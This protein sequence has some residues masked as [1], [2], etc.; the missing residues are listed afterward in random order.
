MREK[1]V[2]CL[3]L[4][5][6]NFNHSA[7]LESL[8]GVW[9]TRNPAALHMLEGQLWSS[10]STVEPKRSYFYFTTNECLR[11]KNYLCIDHLSL[12]YVSDHD[13]IETLRNYHTANP[14]YE[15]CHICNLLYIWRLCW[16]PV[17]QQTNVEIFTRFYIPLTSLRRVLRI[18]TYV[19]CLFSNNIMHIQ[20]HLSIF[21][22]AGSVSQCLIHRINE[23]RIQL[24]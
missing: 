6:E 5:L 7:R 3:L 9:Q 15:Y 16:G 8:C 23:C 18:C 1:F 22:E 19:C 24:K 4:W 11:P 2:C 20:K 10:W 21:N 12:M 14:I 13:Q 17:T